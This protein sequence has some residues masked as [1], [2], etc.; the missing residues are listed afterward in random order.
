MTRRMLVVAVMGVAMFATTR[1]AAAF[2]KKRGGDCATPCA[3][4]AAPCAPQYTVSY[5]EKKVTAYKQE[6]KTKDVKVM[7]NEWV[8]TKETFKYIVAE[9]VV[10]KQKVTVHEMKTKEE[11]Y[12]YQAMEWATVKEKVKVCEYKKVEK[13]VDVVTCE[14]VPVQTMVKKTVCETVCVPVTVTKVVY[15]KPERKG[16]FARCC[17]KGCDD[18]CPP[19]PQTVTCTVMQKQTI[20]K[21]IEVPCT[22]YNRVEKKSK[23]KVTTMEPVWVEKDVDVK[24]CVPVQKEGKRTVCYTVPVEKEIDVR[25]CKN[26][27]KTDTR[28]VKKCVQVEKVVKQTYC[29]NVP[30]ETT[31]KVPVYTPVATPAPAPCATPCETPCASAP[32]T[33]CGGGRT[34]GKLLGGCCGR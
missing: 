33:A 7:V 19:C 8:D 29:E 18:P 31:V 34:R 9:P 12:K 28:I 26:V 30:Y 23:Q 6:M 24:K 13:E 27:E 17:N 3:T 10:V 20:S 14:M 21:V 2:G 32:A 22:T 16:L 11:T 1:E 4:A 5:V 15:P 25:T